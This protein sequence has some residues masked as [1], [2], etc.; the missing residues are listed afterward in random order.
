VQRPMRPLAVPAALLLALLAVASVPFAG[1]N[2]PQP[3]HDTVVVFDHLKGNEWWVEA[4]VTSSNPDYPVQSVEAR[5]VGSGTGGT[6]G[7]GWHHLHLNQWGVWAGSFHIPPGSLV[8]FLAYQSG[9]MSSVWEQQSCPFTHPAGVEQCPG[10]AFDAAF[11]GVRGNEWWVQANVAT[12]GPAVQRV[13]VSVDQGAWRPLAR[14][15][16]GPTAWAASYHIPDGSV[17]RLRATATDGQVDLSSCRQWVPPSGQDAALVDCSASGGFDA[18]FSHVRGNNW[19]AEAVITANRPINAVLLY[20][21]CGADGKDPADMS[22][23][24]DW[25]K[26]VLGDTFIPTGSKVTLF[27]IGE[28]GDE[29]SGGYVWP[30]GTPTSGCPAQ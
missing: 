28:G 22:Y 15:S 3:I 26:W 25:G 18:T 8:E 9:G 21:D 1:A 7:T 16:W 27:A 13:D 2:H 24:A 23:R 6:M 12:N 19:W 10:G 29:T 30:E 4:K 14:Q 20:I 17:V 11:T 5:V